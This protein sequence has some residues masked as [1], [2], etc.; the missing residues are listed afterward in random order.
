MYIVLL[1]ECCNRSD[2]QRRHAF[3]FSRL[4]GMIVTIC[5][6]IYTLRF[7]EHLIDSYRV[8]ISIAGYSKL[9]T[10]V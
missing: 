8:L 7:G 10:P 4:I 1:E 5:E 2:I 6:M 3:K 9:P